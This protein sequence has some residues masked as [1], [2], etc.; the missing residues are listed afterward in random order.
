MDTL[1]KV[2]F[3]YF[4]DLINRSLIQPQHVDSRGKVGACRVHDMV[5]DLITS[6]STEE[7]F[8]TTLDSHQPSDLSKEDTSIIHPKQS[9]KSHHVTFYGELVPCEIIYHL[10]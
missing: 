8:V 10:S 4:N 5:L 9:R 7:N 1:Y 6:L 3:G 2:G